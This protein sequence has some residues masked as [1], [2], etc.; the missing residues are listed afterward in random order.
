MGTPEEVAATVVFVASPG[1]KYITG[2]NFHV[3]GGRVYG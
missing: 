3:N 2:H 1:A